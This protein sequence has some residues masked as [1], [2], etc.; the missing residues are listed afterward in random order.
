MKE[1][2]QNSTSQ[3]IDQESKLEQIREDIEIK[4]ENSARNQLF[5]ILGIKLVI[6]LVLYLIFGKQAVTWLHDGLGSLVRSRSI[7]A[8][9]TLLL[10]Q[11]PFGII[12]FLP[13]LFYFNVMQALLMQRMVESWL[14]SFVGSYFTSLAVY[15]V[16]HN[17]CQESVRK[18]F[19]HYQ[20][21]I[22]FEEETKKYPY[23]DGI[24]LNF[25]LIPVSIKNYL[26]GI[27]SLT[28]GQVAVVLIPG[29]LVLCFLAAMVGSE[30]TSIHEMFSSKSFSEKSSWQKAEFIVSILIL[31]MTIGIVVYIAM[32]YKEKYNQFRQRANSLEPIK[33]RDQ[34]LE[35]QPD[36]NAIL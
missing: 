36:D 25:V 19:E 27:S 15:L 14:V 21:Y 23:R 10:C 34:G 22:M 2:K 30:I 8:T 28:F 26:M 31:V 3:A 6:I 32:H 1:N 29:P 4:E 35:I 20:P 5:L 12:L 18:R 9:I 11:V 7:W 24:I 17:C 33:D 16:V 13:G